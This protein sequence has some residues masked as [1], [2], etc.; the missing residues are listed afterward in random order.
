MKSKKGY[1]IDPKNQSMTEVEVGDYKDIQ[2]HLNCRVFSSAD[3]YLKREPF[4]R[5]GSLN[6]SLYID[7]EGL[8]VDD[9]DTNFC[10]T[11]GIC[12][13][14]YTHLTLPTKA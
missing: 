6:D 4:D 9:E 8:L 7:D 3:Y 13:V 10:F 5:Y 1:L 11:F 12:A 14:S 2:K